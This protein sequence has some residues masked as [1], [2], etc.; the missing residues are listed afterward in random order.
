MS[1]LLTTTEI[2]LKHVNHLRVLANQ[3]ITE[4]GSGHPGIV[5]GAAPILYELYANQ[6][7]INPQDPGMLNRDRFVLSAGHGAA[8]LYATLY[9]AGFDIK[10]SDLSQF[11]TL[12]SKTPGHPE[13][14][15]TPGVEATTGPLGQGLGMAVG[16]AM[17]EAR[18]HALFPSVIN[19]LTFA[20]VGDGDLMEGVSHEVASLAGQQQLSKL[21][22]LYD[23]NDVTLDGSKSRSDTSNQLQR[24]ESY[25]WDIRH[26]ADGNDISMIHDA[27]EN[28]KLSPEP[29]LIAVKNIIGI[30]GPFENSHRAHGTPLTAKQ[31]EDLSAVL[32]VQMTRFTLDENILSSIR[33]RIK[34]RLSTMPVPRKAELIAY[35]QQM[36]EIPLELPNLSEHIKSRPGRQ[37]AGHVLQQFA[38]QMPQIWGGSADLVASTQAEIVGSGLFSPDNRTERNIAFGVREFGMGSIMNGIALHGDT[39]IFGATFLAFSDYM[40]AAI[41]LSALQKLPVIYV[42]THDS[43]TV[44]ED[45]PTHQPIEQLMGL[46]LIPGV[47]VLRPG[48]AEE[49]AS[50]WQFALSSKK[51]PT[52]LIL[53]RGVI[54]TQGDKLSGQLAIQHGAT[55]IVAHESPVVNIIAS[56]SEVQLALAVSQQLQQTN[57]VIS[58]PNMTRFLA[59]SSDSKAEI[60]PKDGAKN[61]IIEAGTTLGWQAVAGDNG[62]VIGIDEFGLS[63]K[64]QTLLDTFGMTTS[65]IVAKINQHLEK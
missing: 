51:R 56:G 2:D 39:K 37:I 20:L 13:K 7:R 45:G 42:F 30:H 17:A 57:R 24:F 50:A 8:L 5:L 10:P 40:K 55:Q 27:I 25:G 58:M 54:G 49:I 14:G 46:R 47:D 59:Q 31:L 38:K 23:D 36:A 11:R 43:L 12:H 21:I 53:S 18:Q 1:E 26:V 62:L 9:A 65:C 22:V 44:G 35:K 41:R 4:A 32:D 60:I 28:A 64:P 63:A 6:M 61:V 3:M 16:M 33:T 48:T 19:H 34:H 15:V 52:V 29:T